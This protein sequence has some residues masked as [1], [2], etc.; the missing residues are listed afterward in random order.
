VW[1][2]WRGAG[3]LTWA[4]GTLIAE[5]HHTVAPYSNDDTAIA[6]RPVT[7]AQQPASLPQVTSAALERFACTTSACEDNCC[8]DWAVPLDETS[9]EKM[10][11]VMSRTPE[12]RERLH[13]LVVIG[14]PAKHAPGRAHIQMNADGACPMLEADSRCGVHASFGEEALTTACSI[15]PRTAV[16]VG[17]RLEIGASLGCPEISR[18]ILLAES[19]E[20]TRLRPAGK[21]M[22]ARPYVGNSV[23]GDPND[24]F[25]HHFFEVRELML[26]LVRRDDLPLPT[27][28]MAAA[29]FADRVGSFFHAGTA[30]FEGPRQGFARR[31]LLAEMVEAESPALL[32][33]LDRDLKGVRV[34]GENT[35]A[36]VATLLLERKR[37]PHSPRFAELLRQAFTSLQEEALGRPANADDAVTPQQLWQVYARRRE[38][39]ETRLGARSA[40]VFAN[41]CEHFLVR[42]P[43]TGSGSLLEYLYKMMVQ[44]AAIRFLTVAHPDL[45]PALASDPDEARRM[46]EKVAVHV[47]QTLT[48]AIGHQVAFLD[49]AFKAGDASG[50]FSF[51]RLLMLAKFV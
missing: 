11:G 49:A 44:L 36:L 9:L 3:F 7:P 45:G 15:F 27:R 6:S 25:A 12:G 21:P 46:F 29:N 23:S 14:K 43:Y 31:R 48:K 47:V 26:R 20:E 28:L 8:R 50:G 39:L 35:A 22:L 38:Q 1:G 16:A 30:E 10:K 51:G 5:S 24:A 32:G 19:V 18:L 2:D 41:Y 40:R 34:P 17:N 42:H 37:L 33:T 13:R 4:A